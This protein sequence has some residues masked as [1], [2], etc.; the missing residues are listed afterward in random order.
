MDTSTV[1]IYLAVGLAAGFLSGLVGIG[2]G[3]VI[4]PVLMYLGFSQHLAQGTVLFMFLL[5]IGIL[6]V[7][8]YHQQGYVDFKSAFVIAS[9]FLIGSYFGSKVAVSIDQVMLKVVFGCILVLLGLKMII[10]R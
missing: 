10:W 3:V 5:P 6:G 2:G 9:T 4:V 7:W 8:N 1:I